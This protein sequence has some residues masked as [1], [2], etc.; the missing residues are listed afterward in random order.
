[1]IVIRCND[2]L[3]ISIDICRLTYLHFPLPTMMAMVLHLAKNPDQLSPYHLKNKKRIECYKK[4]YVIP[5]E[6]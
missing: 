5:K 2:Y 6:I 3:L 1:M 4:G